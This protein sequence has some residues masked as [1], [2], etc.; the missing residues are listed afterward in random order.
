MWSRRPLPDRDRQPAIACLPVSDLKE[1]H[2]NPTTNTMRRCRRSS[3]RPLP[4]RSSEVKSPRLRWARSSSRESRMARRR[5]DLSAQY[6]A[7]RLIGR[8]P[9]KA[10]VWFK[11]QQWRE[12]ALPASQ[13]TIPTNLRAFQ[14]GMLRDEVLLHELVHSGRLL[15]G[16]EQGAHKLE[17]NPDDVVPYANEDGAAY[18]TIE[19]FMTTSFRT[20]TSRRRVKRYSERR[21][22][23][24]VIPTSWIKRSLHQKASCRR[25]ATWLW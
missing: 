3:R 12:E 13:A 1:H 4:T 19:E 8:D 17:P 5:R 15:D 7:G 20:F 24:Q 2:V 14:P 22:A 21:T 9:H 18:E 25:R 16:F 11:P 23:S 6:S 10:V